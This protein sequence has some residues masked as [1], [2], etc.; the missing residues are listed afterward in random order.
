MEE[1]DSYRIKANEL[2]IEISINKAEGDLLH[3]Y[4]IIP[5]LNPATVAL[6]EHIKT[7][8]ITSV[9]VTS[10]EVLD[11]KALEQLKQKFREQASILIKSSL[12]TINEE[13][14]QF[15]LSV[16]IQETLGLDKLEYLINDDNLEEIVVVSSHEPI[17]VY[18]K[19]HGW[20]STN[21]SITTE[22][23][24]QNIA[25]IIARRV[26]RQVT[27]LTPLLDAHLL[28]GDRANVVLFPVSSKGNTITI[29]RFARDPWTM[30]DFLK[31]GT[32]E[33]K[34]LSLMWL[35]I[36]YEMNMLISGGTA[37]GK[38]TVM[39]I[40]MPFIPPTQ[41]ILSIEDSVLPHCRIKY[42]KDGN[43]QSKNIGRIIDGQIKKYGYALPDGTEVAENHEGIQVWS[44]TKEGKI[45]LSTPSAW[46]RHKVRKDVYEVTLSSG[47]NI[48]VTKDHSLF[49][50]QSSVILPI[51]A[52]DIT[53]GDFIATA[54]EICL[55]NAT[56]EKEIISSGLVT[57]QET[58]AV[59]WEPVAKIKKIDYDGYVY[60]ISVPGNESFVCNNVVAHNTRELSLPKF[61]YWCPLVTR[62]PNAEGKGGVSMLDL[63]VNSLRMRPDRIILGEMRKKDQAQVLFEAMH[64]G[65]SVYATLHADALQ[66]T[67]DRLIHPP[68]EVPPNLLEAV[69][70]TVVMFR[71]RRRK[72]RRCYQVGEFLVS[73]EEGRTIVRPNLIYRWKPGED[74]IVPHNK[75]L[76]LFEELSRRTG[77]S[78]PEI[79]QDLREKKGILQYMVKHNTRELNQVGEIMNSYYIDKDALIK[80]L[81]ISVKPK[82]EEQDAITELENA[83]APGEAE[84]A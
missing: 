79:Q 18:H 11:P 66:E 75:P 81:K 84:E 16:L 25:N 26:G 60:D 56:Q 17:R 13:T 46:I 62:D 40:C 69:D 82:E 8:L 24:I 70:L 6:L 31:N 1:I 78:M 83:E 50:M 28:T 12:P 52:E 72:I 22:S 64:T 49:T 71:D 68:I 19:K 39:N 23:Q 53:P 20:M 36:Q 35:A 21:L 10:S 80:K 61:L 47:K 77:M 15:L 73:E 14:L 33:V 7:K 5:Y 59:Q 4:V 58:K 32:I 3:Y 76:H 38:T 43:V 51:R 29:R 74:R 63:L 65:H 30:T 44:M 9:A 55:N 2:D 48:A 34:L 45:V 67:I 27:T 54:Q 41:R 37:S 57:V 42:A